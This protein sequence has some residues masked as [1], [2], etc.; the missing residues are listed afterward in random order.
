[1]ESLNLADIMSGKLPIAELV[2]STSYHDLRPLTTDLFETIQSIIAQ[3]SDADITF[4][5]K[6]AESQEEDGR[7]WTLSHVIA[8]L[9]AGL[10]AAAASAAMLARGVKVEGRLHYETP[11][12]KIQTVQQLHDR[13]AESQRMCNAFL[14]AWPD[15]PFLDIT[16]T[17]VPFIG[18][19]NAVQTYKFGIIH[20]QTH[21]EQLRDIISQAQVARV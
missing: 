4:V 14:D 18:P 3:V 5:P 2:G 10:E 13:L 12:E 9:T 19:T 1:M 16:I 11:W 17:P 20:A 6:D 15:T 8:H 21:F 7:G